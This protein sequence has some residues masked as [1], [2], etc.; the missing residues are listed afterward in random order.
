MPDSLPGLLLEEQRRPLFD[1]LA[2]T[3]LQ[4]LWLYRFAA[5][6]SRALVVAAAALR[7]GVGLKKLFP[8]K[9]LHL[10]DSGLPLRC[11]ARIDRFQLPPVPQRV[12]VNIERSKEHMQVL[13]V[14]NN[15]EHGKNG[16]EMRP[17]ENGSCRHGELN[18]FII[19]Q[20]GERAGQ[21]SGPK[22]A[23]AR[24]QGRAGPVIQRFG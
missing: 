2:E 15:P 24:L 22:P 6:V 8:G 21:G 11:P 13:G 3:A 17:P 20:T 1:M 12:P 7:A 9:I 10:I 19:K 23:A 4:R 14:G 16:Q 5:L 18:R